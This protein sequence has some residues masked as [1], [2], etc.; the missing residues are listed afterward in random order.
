MCLCLDGVIQ[1]I[2][3]PDWLLTLTPPPPLLL[4]SK[5]F[6]CVLVLDGVI[7]CTENDEFAYQEMIAHIPL[8]SHP[9]P[10]RVSAWAVATPFSP[11]PFLSLTFYL[12]TNPSLPPSFPPSPFIPPS[13]PTSSPLYFFPLSNFLHPSSLTPTLPL[14]PPSPFY[15]FSSLIFPPSCTYP[16]PPPQP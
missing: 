14:S 5:T 13:F 6:G 16:F 8:F 15:C 1:C 10:R 4:C 7:Q 3:A 12:D 11:L 9:N 2:S